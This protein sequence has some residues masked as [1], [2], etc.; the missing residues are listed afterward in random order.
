MLKKLLVLAADCTFKISQISLVSSS[1]NCPVPKEPFVF[2]LAA[3]RKDE[4]DLVF[5]RLDQ[6]LVDPPVA[7]SEL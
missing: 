2:V 4:A 5:M 7:K 3:G 6:S 1:L